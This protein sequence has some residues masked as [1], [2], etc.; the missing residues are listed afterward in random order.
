LSRAARLEALHLSP[1]HG[2]SKETVDSLRLL[3]GQGVEG[4]AHCG[5][6]VQHRSRVAADPSQ[7]NLRQVHLIHAELFDALSAA[8]F[9]VR[10][11][12]LG[13]NLTTRGV[14]LLSLPVGSRLVV[15]E[16][17][18][19]VT[20]LRNPCQQINGFQ[21]GLLKQVL[22]VDPD[23][24]PLRLAGVMGIVSRG[25]VLTTGDVIEVLLP[26]G[27]HFPLTRV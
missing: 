3:E 2:F 5:V 25:G 20:G 8:G 26:E 23:G 15:G 6:T 17:V 27:E 21:A 11:G 13:E 22:K 12:E 24:R 1:V 9:T 16:A 4:D 18:V 14:D 19:T 10:P 7:P